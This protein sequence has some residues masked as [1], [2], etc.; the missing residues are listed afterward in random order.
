MQISKMSIIKYNYYC[1][2]FMQ[3]KLV[4]IRLYKKSKCFILINE[5]IALNCNKVYSQFL[6]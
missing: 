2:I 5:G 6:F 1:I 4:I 3:I